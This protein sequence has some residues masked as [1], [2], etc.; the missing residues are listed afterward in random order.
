MLLTSIHE[1]IPPQEESAMQPPKKIEQPVNKVVAPS[2][3]STSA[4]SERSEQSKNDADLTQTNEIS[5]VENSQDTLHPETA[6]DS[7]E[8]EGEGEGE[9]SHVVLRQLQQ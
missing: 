6:E 3:E 5:I 2:M 8:G 9:R 7:I 1:S 4:Q